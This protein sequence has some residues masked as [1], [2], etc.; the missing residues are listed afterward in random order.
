M[1]N[2]MNH[3]LYVLVSFPKNII[4]GAHVNKFILLYKNIA[5]KGE[6][7]VVVL[8]LWNLTEMQIQNTGEPF[9]QVNTGSI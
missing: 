1:Q 6:I 3:V 4:H 5:G 2:K 9:R 8:E 7:P